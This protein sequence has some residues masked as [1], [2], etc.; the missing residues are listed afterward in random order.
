MD[1]EPK[2]QNQIDFIEAVRKQSFMDDKGYFILGARV[3]L[4]FNGA[5]GVTIDG[6]NVPKKLRK[7]S[8]KSDIAKRNRTSLSRFALSEL[9]TQADKFGVALY[10]QC[11]PGDDSIP[12]SK[13]RE[14]FK[15]AGFKRQGEW[16]MVRYPRAINNDQQLK[17]A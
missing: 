17:A 5:G 14:I 6:I 11:I 8:M 7:S 2:N 12:E 13:L 1:I 4:K 15:D 16:E 3:L 9:A 10:F